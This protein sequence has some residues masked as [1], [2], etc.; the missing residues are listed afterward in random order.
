VNVD[1]R[2]AVAVA[3][4][5]YDRFRCRLANI[6][7]PTSE[8][9]VQDARYDDEP[10]PEVGRRPVV[11]ISEGLPEDVRDVIGR[12]EVDA[13]EVD[14]GLVEVGARAAPHLCSQLW[15]TR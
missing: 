13:G 6:G 3:S 7:D 14:Q 10:V 15:V 1:H 2:I 5:P 4:P 8:A 9:A 11:V 12:V